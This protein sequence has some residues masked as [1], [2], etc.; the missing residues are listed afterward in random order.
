MFA[1]TKKLSMNTK[2]ICYAYEIIYEIRNLFDEI[3]KG[4]VKFSSWMKI[5]DQVKKF[6]DVGLLAKQ[7]NLSRP[8]KIVYKYSKEEKLGEYEEHFDLIQDD[9]KAEK[10]AR[11]FL[12]LSTRKITVIQTKPGQVVNEKIVIPTEASAHK[13]TAESLTEIVKPI[14]TDDSVKEIIDKKI[15]Y[16]NNIDKFGSD[17]I[18]TEKKE[19]IV[20]P[21]TTT[22][23]NE[24]YYTNG[25]QI[26][27]N[28]LKPSIVT[29]YEKPFLVEKQQMESERVLPGRS[30]IITQTDD[31]HEDP[32]YFKRIEK[33][34]E[35]LRR[36]NQE[37]REKLA[38][39]ESDQKYMRTRGETKPIETLTS[40]TVHVMSKF[41]VYLRHHV[42]IRDWNL[43]IMKTVTP[44]YT[45]YKK[46][47]CIE[48][49]IDMDLIATG[50]LSGHVVFW[51][52]SNFSN[53]KEEKILNISPNSPIKSLLYL[54]DG[55]TLYC[56][57]ADGEINKIT[58]S[59]LNYTVDKVLD[60][61]QSVNRLVYELNGYSILAASGKN[62]YEIDIIN[63]KVLNFIEAHDDIITD[64]IYNL[65]KEMFV[66]C[67]RDKNIK[68][69]HSK[70]KECLGILQ[71]HSGPVKSICFAYSHDYMY[72]ASIGKDSYITLWNLTDRSLTRTFE[73]SDMPTKVIYLWD[74]KSVLV[75]HKNGV[76][77]LWDIEKDETKDFF[78][79]K[80]PYN[81]GCYLDDGHNI[82]LTSSNG[83]L[84]FWNAK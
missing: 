11:S 71:G 21:E 2:K 29:S 36:K 55:K 38:V 34:M 42:P 83:S 3:K 60:L 63:N 77:T 84:E 28:L 20:R 62:I 23:Y 16:E 35:D 40:S 78:N 54:N 58:I 45:E 39:T 19:V 48:P 18:S 5:P 49:L 26:Q 57:S 41:P 81:N 51:K 53:I 8:S 74:K 64:L 79:E 25:R 7:K 22:D 24:F 72:L 59:P 17:N 4:L 43:L 66:S 13:D 47:K 12:D 75:T 80:L 70:T 6:E 37:L 27:N 52:F 67:A 9:L 73:L 31:D 10:E 68:I 1:Y 14:R 82:V 56:G 50:T 76:F 44:S 61:E 33:Q 30:T 32:E 65:Q 15:I 69:W 46:F